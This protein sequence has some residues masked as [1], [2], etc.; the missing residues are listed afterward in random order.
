M[1][2]LLFTILLPFLSMFAWAQ[3]G[4]AVWAHLDEID[5]QIIPE[6][7]ALRKGT[8][9]NG[10]T[11]YVRRCTQ[12]VPQ[13][14]S[15]YLLVK[16]GSLQEKD[17]ERGIAHFVEHMMFKGTKH[18]P[19]NDVIGFMRRN[20]IVFGHDSN[21]FT[22]F[23]T[24]R[25]IL[26]DVPANNMEMLDSCLLL[27]RDWAGDATIDPK[28]VETEHNVIVEEWRSGSMAPFAK[29]WKDDI[30]NNSLYAKRL[31]VG[32]MDIVQHC[33]P[34][35]VRNFYERWYQPQ[36]QAVVVV[37]D[38]DPDAMMEGIKRLFSDMKRGKSKPSAPLMIPDWNSPRV[39][40]YQ[41]AKQPFASVYMLVKMPEVEADK[42]NAVGE[43]RKGT[44]REKV[45]KVL[46]KKLG[47]LKQQHREIYEST[48]KFMQVNDLT[49]TQFLAFGF[50]ASTNRWE[51]TLE[52]LAKQVELMRRQS[53]NDEEEKVAM[54]ANVSYTVEEVFTDADSKNY[55]YPSPPYNEDSTAIVFNDTTFTIGEFPH[56]NQYRSNECIVNFFEGKTIMWD[57]AKQLAERHVGNTIS[58]EQLNQEFRNLTNGH[59]MF[60][61]LMFPE[62]ATLPNE[63]RVRGILNRVKNLSDE[64][65]ADINE[66][67][68]QPK[69][70][71]MLDVDTLDIPTVPGTVVKTTVL[72]D[73]ISEVMLSN[74]VKVVLWKK[75]T[76]G[77][78]INFTFVRPSGFSVL[79]DEDIQFH[80]MLAFVVRRY[81]NWN[82]S[83]SLMVKPFE[84]IYDR[85]VYEKDKVE[86]FLK[87]LYATLT[88][89][90][91][92]VAAFEEWMQGKQTGAVATST[93]M[94]Q[95]QL[96]IAHLPAVSA[97]RLMPPTLEE[98]ETSYTLDRFREVVK[99]YYSNYNGSV[100]V[101][102][103]KY[104]TDSIMPSI[105]KYVAALPSKPEPVKRMAWPADHYK[106]TNSTV[107][108]KIE[109]AAPYCATNLY[110]TWENDYAYTQEI[111][112]HNLVLQSVLGTLLFN[113][114]RVQHSDIYTPSC[115]VQ[116]DLLPFPR[117]K[118]DISYTCNPTQRERIAQDVVQLMQQ[119]A[120][121]DLITQELIDNYVKE[122]EKRKDMFKD[123]EASL[124]NE[125]VMRELNGIV[126]KQG[127]VTYIK[128]VTPASLKSHL[129]QLLTKGNLHI[130]YLTTE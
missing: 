130:G 2:K 104:D 75:K 25:Y 21:A 32:D 117:M 59:N 53:F 101:V 30:F 80:D 69:K 127:D 38:F 120:E 16:A 92:D 22:G 62:S 56:P 33:S 42:K 17:N 73:S 65:L 102:Q 115:G 82:G 48:A 64:K 81:C 90:E 4:N 68:E 128:Q 9:D 91:V 55:N 83:T 106:T 85:P 108:E 26:N 46:E 18:F 45:R 112:A 126:V 39:G 10:L 89:T 24:V 76:D 67:K 114:L 124:R 107:V 57:M 60:L 95:A 116:D 35:L 20:G 7:T 44:L 84:D 78:A 111:H 8:L 61:A 70:L 63:E 27:L 71:E 87:M 129:Q 34:Q 110:Y 54:E 12:P 123:T 105:L 51:Q 103:G 125:Y 36:N 109:N 11:Y 13:R 72:N 94:A 77:N 28:D 96:R 93:P 23:N 5:K 40:I 3:E 118:C 37:G 29:L 74:G 97:K 58:K 121:G 31:P 43:I 14:A 19:G 113:T 6:D 119:M 66:K 52:W 15:F 122:C 98:L 47:A 100:L 88:S 50:D 49:G 1:V 99:D 79:K 41:H 86:S